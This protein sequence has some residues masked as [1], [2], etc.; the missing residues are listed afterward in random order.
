[1]MISEMPKELIKLLEEAEA[2][3]ETSF[4]ITTIPRPAP[5]TCKQEIDPSKPDPEITYK[6]AI[7]VVIT[8]LR[9]DPDMYR[10]FKDNIAVAF[11]DTMRNAG[12]EF[13]KL[14]EISNEAAKRFLDLLIKR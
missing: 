8:T 7:E 5:V 10:V 3:G 12:Y 6:K 13:P 2:L 9:R 4:F 14:H 1:M 11:Q